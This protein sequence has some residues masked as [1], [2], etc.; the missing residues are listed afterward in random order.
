MS[1]CSNVYSPPGPPPGRRPRSCLVLF[2]LSF[3][4][5]LVFL[6]SHLLFSSSFSFLLSCPTLSIL[7]LVFL[8]LDSFHSLFAF[9]T[10]S[11]L[12]SFSPSLIFPSLSCLFFSTFLIFFLFFWSAGQWRQ[13][14]RLRMMMMKMDALHLCGP[15]LRCDVTSCC[16]LKVVV[17]FC[18]FCLCFLP[19]M[20]SSSRF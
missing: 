12:Y 4:L 6:S 9:F 5:L 14:V 2:S 13:E 18:L 11:I 15:A 10:L 16:R 1:R 7:F 19:N 17:F 3:T 20:R 8:L